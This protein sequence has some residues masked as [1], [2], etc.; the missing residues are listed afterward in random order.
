M[1]PVRK[2]LLCTGALVGGLLIAEGVVRWGIGYPSYGVEAKVL[3][4]RNSDNGIQNIY[5]PHSAYWTVEGGN[6]VFHRNNIGL[7][8]SDI[9]AGPAARYVFV[10]GSSFI[11]ASQVPPDSMA[12]AV[13]QRLLARKEPAVQV[14]NLGHSGH[15]AYDDYFRSLYFSRRYRPEAVILVLQDL[16]LSWLSH[17]PHPLTFVRPA[18]FG[19]ELHSMTSRLMIALR[20]ASALGNLLAEWRRGVKGDR[21]QTEA[22]PASSRTQQEETGNGRSPEDLGKCLEAFHA[23]YG[24]AFHVVSMMSDT[25][26]NGYLHRLCDNV[27]M[28][29]IVGVIPPEDHLLGG[30]GHLAV[31]GNIHLGEIL[32]ESLAQPSRQ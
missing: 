5:L 16:E 24:D 27:H 11:E 8:G 21:G 22:A 23:A 26:A 7:P 4:I 28:P 13:L 10:L 3:G 9:H 15:D 29:F 30:S 32:Y 2:I 1:V 17:H 6:R 18:E 19:T 12:T 14:L 31:R 20:N 25:A